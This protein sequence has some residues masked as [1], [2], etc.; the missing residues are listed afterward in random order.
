[1]SRRVPD[2][3]FA[4]ILGILLLGLVASH[5][6]GFWFHAADRE[7]AVRAVGGLAAAQRIA[8][9]T[10]LLREAPA[11]Q[12]PRLAA[13]LSDSGFRISLLSQPPFSAASQPGGAAAALRAMLAHA[14]P[15]PGL[16]APLV[17]L[18]AAAPA[19]P[20]PMM[21]P[22]WRAGWR[23]DAPGPAF[24][25]MRA[26]SA[27]LPL[28]EGGWI[29]F[30]TGLPEGG[31]DVSPRFLLSMGLMAAVIILASVV[32][33]RQA[34][35]PLATL[36]AAAERLGHDVT[37][38]PL[39][40]EGTREMRAAAN[41]FNGMQ[42]RLRHL[43]E[44]RMQMLAAISHDIRTP[45]TLLRLRIETLPEDE[46]QAR[47]LAT[48]AEMEGMV[49]DM[50]SF[51]R[52]EVV[53]EPVR[54]TDIPALVQSLVDDMADG[55]LA[56]SADR[57]D[58]AVLDCRPSALRRAAANLIGN[59][60]AYGKLAHVALIATP[61]AVEIRV[62]DEGPGLP[63]AELARVTEPFYR[64]ERSRSREGGGIGLGLAITRAIAEAH[65]GRLELANR[66]QGGLRARIVLPQ[67][68]S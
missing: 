40:V 64:A 51:A 19:L 5:A 10:R 25:T 56:V 8:N 1:M 47:M 14:A 27:A 42:A 39:A 49:A 34:T 4:R 62:E 58:A 37:A 32:A 29:A 35:R 23:G 54:R 46:D 13:A 43:L 67:G 61:A 26:L 50:L 3:L 65:G 15:A 28:A 60:L 31:S 41:A 21:G 30:R 44:S 38:P 59:A 66:R 18:E 57:L 20:M 48:I 63:P 55:G 9:A 16:P 52:D 53:S 45:L 11:E 33:V 12:R 17:A 7:E 24:A 22:G 36:A 68:K 6:A 2:S